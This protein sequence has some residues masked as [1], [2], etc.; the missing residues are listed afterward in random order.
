MTFFQVL[1]W[2]LTTRKKISL[3]INHEGNNGFQR[4]KTINLTDY[5]KVVQR[6]LESWQEEGIGWNISAS[7]PHHKRAICNSCEI[8]S[9]KLQIFKKN[10][11]YMHKTEEK[12]TTHFWLNHTNDRSKQT[13]K[14]RYSFV[15]SNACC[16][17]HMIR[18]QPK[19]SYK[20]VFRSFPSIALRIP[21]AHSHA[22]LARAH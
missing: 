5:F 3:V 21:S 6:F 17:N 4:L 10:V 12:I 13:A 19:L 7:F 9:V 14:L 11:L 20:M 2:N 22:W 18:G 15:R 1:H 8:I 16:W